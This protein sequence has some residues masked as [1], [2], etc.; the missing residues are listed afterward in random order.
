MCYQLVNINFWEKKTSF[1]GVFFL[2]VFAG[3]SSSH[4][5]GPHM[6]NKLR[7]R[8]GL[9]MLVTLAMP[10]P[11]CVLEQHGTA[12]Q[13]VPPGCGGRVAAACPEPLQ[14]ARA[15]STP[16]AGVPR[17]SWSR[18]LQ[19]E[20]TSVK[21]KEFTGSMEVKPTW[22][23]KGG[24]SQKQFWAAKKIKAEKPVESQSEKGA[25]SNLWAAPEGWKQ[26]R[27]P[28]ALT[29]LQPELQE[30][31]EAAPGFGLNPWG[32]IC[33]VGFLQSV[34]FMIQSH[35]KAVQENLSEK[36][37]TSAFLCWRWGDG[38]FAVRPGEPPTLTVAPVRSKKRCG[39]GFF[40]LP[41]WHLQ[42]VTRVC[43]GCVM[44]SCTSNAIRMREL[45][46]TKL[47]LYF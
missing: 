10:A 24:L 29:L 30:S 15:R 6:A 47:F 18:F 19:G 26:R 8:R 4:E 35:R 5:V 13:C 27:N 3:A 2:F 21:T 31:E 1:F 16:P 46:Q 40:F 37:E 38:S 34:V 12:A 36:T 14:R 23:D 9:R 7:A 43:P 25:T 45:L 44:V 42:N 32:Y 20:N 28:I 33:L 11:L 17:A 41:G 22:P 39:F